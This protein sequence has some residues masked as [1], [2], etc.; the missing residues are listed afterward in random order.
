MTILIMTLN[1]KT[2]LTMT[3][4]KTVYTGDMNYYYIILLITDF[5]YN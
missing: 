3:M 4:V 5:T 1:L 2:L